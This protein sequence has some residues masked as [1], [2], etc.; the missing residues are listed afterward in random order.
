MKNK[1]ENDFEF[2]VSYFNLE[3]TDQ[4][5]LLFEKKVKEDISF[6]KKV[7]T[8]KESVTIVEEIDPNSEDSIRKQ[9]WSKIIRNTKQSKVVQL[10]RI[11]GIAASLII[12]FSLVFYFSSDKIDIDELTQKAWDKN[13]GL[14]F[15]L[16]G[17]TSDSTKIRLY[18]A[19]RLYKNKEYDEVLAQL[20]DYDTSSS[21][22]GDIL[23]LR[24][25]SQH[26]MNRSK[27]A[28]KTLDTLNSF[29]PEVSQ[30]YKGL[31]YLDSKNFENAKLY[32]VIPKD[33]QE[34]IKL[35][36]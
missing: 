34:E 19:A 17:Q 4:E 2:I 12:G 9:E 21:S 27:V 26:K 8:Y 5:M 6:A 7:A 25:L 32:I 14:D 15:V 3:L 29:S 36:K 22:Y 23:L 20:K 10:R 30:W 35:R 13:A 1:H 24:A 31:I 11:I 16:R 28:L 33:S 18:K